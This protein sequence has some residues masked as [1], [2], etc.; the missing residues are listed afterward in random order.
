MCR[1]LSKKSTWYPSLEKWSHNAIFI[2]DTHFWLFVVLKDEK[3][4]ILVINHA[5][6]YWLF[7]TEKEQNIH[8][9]FLSLVLKL[10]YN[11][12]AQFQYGIYV[13]FLISSNT[14][15]TIY[16]LLIN[17]FRKPFD[18][19]NKQGPNLGKKEAKNNCHSSIQ[20]LSLFSVQPAAVFI[21]ILTHMFV[22]T[23]LLLC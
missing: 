3:I 14:S 11:N 8:D 7:C 23:T 17:I 15:K 5:K 9:M 6:A 13:S 16:Y 10:E 22:G 21:G 1:L 20:S 4:G 2:L 19:G 12:K 18:Q